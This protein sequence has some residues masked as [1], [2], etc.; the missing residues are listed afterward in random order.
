VKRVLV[1]KPIH[2]DAL[3]LLAQ[4]VEVLT[5]FK[6]SP[7]EIKA[8]LPDVQG[9]IL[10]AG[11]K[12]DASTIAEV[13]SSMEVIGRH[14][15]GLDIVDV[16]SATGHGIPVVF[17]PLGPT[18]STAEHAFLLMMAVA[19]KL[20]FLDR[21]VRAGNF[22]VR[23]QVVGTEL[24]G[25]KVGVVG[26]GNIGRRFAEM[27]RGA[28]QMEIYAY[29]PFIAPQKIADWGAVYQESVLMMAAQVDFLSLHI[30][31]TPDTHH[32]V[33]AAV[34]EALGPKGYLINCARGPVV[35]EQALL[36]ALQEN[37]IAGA[38]LDVFDPE[39]PQA[40]NPLFA[41]DNVVLTPHLASFTDEGRQRMGL[42]VAEDVLRVLRGEAPRYLANPAVFD[43]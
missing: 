30:P 20:T 6:A 34:L 14:G 2:E 36:Q 41:L 43:K 12:M 16:D 13:A 10:C 22:H 26:F 15:A 4:E 9:M 11:M 24:Q 25:K 31:A 28:L 35:D 7:A 38:A 8:M 42:M 33:D 37:R 29:D 3:A 21:S 19:R 32:I 23:D 5:P 40:D 17:T 1:N 18:E 39:P 27:C